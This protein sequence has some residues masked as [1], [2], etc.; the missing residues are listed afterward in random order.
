M[1]KFR[2]RL[3]ALLKVKEHIEKERQ[4]EHGE[5]LKKVH[6]REQE[7][8]QILRD[9]EKTLAQQRERIMTG[10]SV[11]EMLVYGRHLLKLKRDLLTEKEL[12]GVLRKDAENKREAL[13][14]ATKERKIYQ[15]LKERRQQQHNEAVLQQTTNENDEIALNSFRLP[16]KGT[17]HRL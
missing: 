12:L 1:K 9:K 7:L 5:A 3:Q 10:L 14:N 8:K 2:Y 6:N 13:L 4:K 17:K 16:V 15:K 11:A